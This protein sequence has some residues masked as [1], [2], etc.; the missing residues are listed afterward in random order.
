[1]RGGDAVPVWGGG[2]GRGVGLFPAG[3]ATGGPAQARYAAPALLLC[4]RRQVQ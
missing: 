2:V 4:L 3:G 1:M